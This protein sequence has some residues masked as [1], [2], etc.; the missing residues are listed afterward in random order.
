M[1]ELF[2]RF[3]KR[4]LAFIEDSLSKVEASKIFQ[5]SKRTF[6]VDSGKK[7][8]GELIVKVHDQKPDTLNRPG[9]T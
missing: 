1:Y 7:E 8:Q 5:V 4:V 6:F 3:K 2:P 9:L